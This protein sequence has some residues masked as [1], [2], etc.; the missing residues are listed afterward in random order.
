MN[1]R[2]ILISGAGI[3]GPC[4]AYWL[5]RFGFEPVLLERAPRLRSGGYIVDFWGLGFEVAERMDLLPELRRVA[6]AIDEVRIVNE[7]GRK[8]GGFSVD[9]FRNLLGDRFVSILRSDLSR[10][11]YKLIDGK[12]RIIFGDSV[13]AVEQDQSSVRVTFQSGRV[14][15]FDLLIGADGLHS[16]VR[17]AIFGPQSQFENYLGYYAASFDT[18]GYRPRDEQAYVGFAAPGRQVSRYSLRGDRTVFF[19]A[20][21]SK[22]KLPVGSHE[23]TAQKEILRRTFS[24]DA[25]ECPAILARMDQSE[26]LYFDSVSQIVMKSW[27]KARVALVGDACFCPSL[28]AGQGAALAMAAAYI[29]AGELAKAGGNH[30]IA[31]PAYEQMLRPLMDSKQHAAR[32]FAASFAPRTRIGIFLRN[33]ATELMTHSWVAERFMGRLLSDTLNLPDYG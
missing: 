18:D 6:Y 26:D 23:T 3:A 20:F 15:R 22:T 5:L 27:T 12:A 1:D 7:R 8:T 9:V 21:A 30:Q 4:L 24:K 33:R 17:S 32:R 13:F 16:A 11:I 29:L 2:A 28:L 31:F 25:W 10:L 14:E 19:F